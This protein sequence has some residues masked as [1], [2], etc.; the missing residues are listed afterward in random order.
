MN[1]L[2]K[3]SKSKIKIILFFCLFVLFFSGEGVGGMRTRVSEFFFT[4]NSKLKF[5]FFLRGGGGG[6]GA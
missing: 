4:K 6:G 3:E 2:Y 1:L 5:F